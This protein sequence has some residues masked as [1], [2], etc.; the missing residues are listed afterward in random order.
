MEF[1]VNFS[2]A[3]KQSFALFQFTPYNSANGI[4]TGNKIF[5]RRSR[6]FTEKGKLVGNGAESEGLPKRISST[7]GAESRLKNSRG[8]GV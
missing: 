4:S 8:R 3:C 1:L 7:A 6:I 2:R 5:R